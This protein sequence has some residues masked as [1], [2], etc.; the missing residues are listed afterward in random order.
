MGSNLAPKK[1]EWSI[2]HQRFT[3]FGDFVVP[4]R[5]VISRPGKRRRTEVKIVFNEVQINPTFLGK[6]HNTG[7]SDDDDWDDEDWE[8]AEGPATISEQQSINATVS[9]DISTKASLG[10][11]IPVVFVL[12]SAGLLERGDLCGPRS[13]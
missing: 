1:W 8:D 10:S 2:D 12:D 6:T 13:N 7:E 4:T 3:E 9:T 5:T 11:S